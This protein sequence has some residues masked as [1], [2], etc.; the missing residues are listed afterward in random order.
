MAHLGSGVNADF[1]VDGSCISGKRIE[2]NSINLHAVLGEG[3]YEISIFYMLAEEELTMIQETGGVDFTLHV[4]IAPVYERPDRFNCRAGRLPHDLNELM[5]SEGFLQY[6]DSVFVDIYSGIVSTE[7]KL[8]KTSV[9]RITSIEPPGIDVKI[10]IRKEERT[11]A[12]SDN[13]GGSEGLLLEMSSGQYYID[14]SFRSSMV[15][16]SDPNFCDTILLVIGLA[17]ATFISKMGE[18]L[19]LSE[20]KDSTDEI[21]EV[22]KSFEAFLSTGSETE[23]LIEPE[24]NYYTLSLDTLVEGEKTIIQTSFELTAKTNVYF[25]VFSDFLMADVS[26]LIQKKQKKKI[27]IVSERGKKSF[28]GELPS[29]KYFFLV[30]SAP[31]SK[32]VDQ[33]QSTL[34]EKSVLPKCVAF[35]LRIKASKQEST[36]LICKSS[37]LRY[38]PISFNIFSMLPSKNTPIDG[39]PTSV[40]FSKQFIMQGSKD[41]SSFYLSARSNIKIIAQSNESPMQISIFKGSTSLGMSGSSTSKPPFIYSIYLTLQKDKVYTLEVQHFSIDACRPY[42]LLVEIIPSDTIP[43]ISTCIEFPPENGL[44]H[45]RTLGYQGIFDMV[46]GSGY[47]STS[48]EPVFTYL[49][50]KSKEYISRTMLNITAESA[51]ITGH[52]QSK[53][54][55]VGLIMQIES[56]GEIIEWGKFEAAHRYELSSVILSKGI[57]EVV[58]KEVTKSVT[59]ACISFTASVL[60]EDIGFWDD[61]T[62]LVRKSQS[63]T[64]PDQPMSLQVVGQMEGSMLHWKKVL[65]IDLI[66]LETDFEVDIRVASIINIFIVPQDNTKFKIAVFKITDSDPLE[67]F[68]ESYRNAELLPA[69]YRI[70]IIYEFDFRFPKPSLCPGFEIDLEILPLD[71]LQQ[72]SSQYTCTNTQVLP[73][74]L[75]EERSTF[76][77]YGSIDQLF[78]LDYPSP[79]LLTIYFS[80]VSILSGYIQLQLFDSAS[81]ILAQSKNI[82]NWGV[83]KTSVS[84]GAYVLRVATLQSSQDTCWP[85]EIYIKS[86]SKVEACA[87]GKLP[88]SLTESSTGVYG[89]PQ[90]KDGSISFHGQFKITEEHPKE[91]IRIS[92]PVTSIIRVLTI[93]SASVHVESAIYNQN[94]Y[95]SPIAYSKNKSRYSSFLAELTAQHEPYNLILTFLIQEPQECLHYTLKIVIEP[96]DRLPNMLECKINYHQNL[97]PS[98]SIDLSQLSVYG[99]EN[100]AIFDKWINGVD[101]PEGA[102]SKGKK[103]TK[104]IY[105]LSLSI[106]TQGIVSLRV[107]YD[108]LT[109][110]L[111]L[112]LKDGSES[113][114]IGIWEI[115][116]DDELADTE[117]FSCAISGFP[118]SPGTYQVYLKQGISAGQLL[119]K[120][121]S[122]SAC[123]PFGFFIEFIPDS[124]SELNSIISINPPQLSNHNLFQPLQL[125]I[126]FRE[127]V[128]TSTLSSIFSLKSNTDI[129]SPIYASRETEATIVKLK[130]ARSALKPN[131]CYELVVDSVNIAPNGEKNVYCTSSCSC[132]PSANAECSQ[133]SQC[134]CP[135]P[136]SG[137]ACYECVEG[138]D[139]NNSVC[140]EILDSNPRVLSLKF[141]DQIV[142][143]GSTIKLYIDFTSAPY[144]RSGNKINYV[145]KQAL[146]ESF[147]L[148]CEESII[149]P[150]SILALNKGSLKWVLMYSP[151]HL[152]FGKTYNL[153]VN[154]EEIRTSAGGIYL[155]EQNEQM[156]VSVENKPP[157]IIL[158]CNSHGQIKGLVC[159]CE[160]PYT[161]LDCKNCIAGYASNQAGTC[162]LLEQ[163]E[164]TAADPSA[165]LKFISPSVFTIIPQGKIIEIEILLSQNAYNSNGHIIDTLSNSHYMQAAFVLQKVKSDF[166]VAA[167]WIRCLDSKGL[168]WLLEFSTVELNIN[169]VFS[170]M[171]VKYILYTSE[172]LLFSPPSIQLPRLQ[173][174]V[175]LNCNFG[176]QEQ[177]YCICEENYKGFLCE[178]CATGYYLSL[179]GE[180]LV[181]NI[182][183][184]D[185][186]TVIKAEK[187][188]SGVI[189][190]AYLL[191]YVLIIGAVVACIQ[192]LLK[193]TDLRQEFEMIPREE[194]ENEEINLHDT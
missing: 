192:L 131:N 53:I 168:R 121:P 29:G 71:R 183:A 34:L 65:P 127:P 61:I 36:S 129:V 156:Q 73:F 24:I 172:N 15:E 86:T 167:N 124:T 80:Y 147:V 140:E 41:A 161:G 21:N 28:Y 105:Q 125:Y 40:I 118:I 122:V 182:L 27:D 79:Q 1:C 75:T 90:S 35:Q 162:E 166:I 101:M 179:Q 141:N 38:L 110:D 62:N 76:L 37:D 70:R 83:L 47:S 12:M 145:N 181:E 187:D 26:I 150:A 72:I 95:D 116:S 119:Q 54:S 8:Q 2:K 136:Y 170:F 123:F 185:T 113:L 175:V 152:E 78:V 66:S 84:E 155:V 191:V 169:T 48:E 46:I 184:R 19:K 64:Y 58:I 30:V 16:I 97:L 138:F 77:I 82:E 44:F 96:G 134:I 23:F 88:L 180:C 115:L 128:D 25:E 50:K 102:I 39:G 142:S 22:F 5:D 100:Y 174:G 81:A 31:L 107:N 163:Q 49:Q 108:F 42:S 20:C 188:S 32:D 33:S 117:N 164:E 133:K 6:S 9:I 154:T 149:K 91:I 114:A 94:I 135:E 68:Y 151:E 98:T 51:M 130:F 59:K 144:D 111:N 120:Y 112:E 132:N 146:I 57:Y 99:N 157:S 10:S 165:Y 103:N 17:P 4:N 55:E 194:P 190:L 52:I 56:E 193:K 93:S 104:F 176:L 7:I 126:T 148:S 14:I 160:T 3:K 137:I 109:N 189:M 89:G 60:I 11:I 177:D 159:D 173:I 87:G 45:E 69:E 106:P 43:E 18:N 153:V 13:I 171:Q 85:L 178:E 63:C 92:A 186:T 143:R 67:F 158:T 74:S 139:F